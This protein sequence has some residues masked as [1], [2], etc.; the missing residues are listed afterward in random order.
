MGVKRA[1]R[2][3]VVAKRLCAFIG[4]Y[5]LPAELITAAVLTVVLLRWLAL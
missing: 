2:L 1:A 5:D 4:D 3:R